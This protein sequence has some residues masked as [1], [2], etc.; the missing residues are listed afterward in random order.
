M[1][2]SK[3]S[4]REISPNSEY[5]RQG[6]QKTQKK[7][8]AYTAGRYFLLDC[9]GEYLPKAK[10]RMVNIH[11]ETY[12]IAPPFP[13]YKTGVET[14]GAGAKTCISIMAVNS[15]K[16][17]NGNWRRAWGTWE[18][19]LYTWTPTLKWIRK[20]CLYQ[21]TTFFNFSL[22]YIFVCSYF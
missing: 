2:Q 16:R 20:L 8:T 4:T 7:Q 5:R 14:S 1:W 17:C 12:W 11:H 6:H 19:A 21:N 18:R 9:V 3:C 15:Q 22:T 13:T 10:L